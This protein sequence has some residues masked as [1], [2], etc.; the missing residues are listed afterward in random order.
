MF[1]FV[2]YALRG[3]WRFSG[4]DSRQ[5]FW[6]WVGF[7][8]VCDMVLAAAAILPAMFGTMARLQAYAAAH[9]DEVTVESSPGGTSISVH[10]P[11][12]GLMPDI[13]GFMVTNAF[14]TV[15]SVLL[16]AAAVTRRL[17]DTGRR[18]WW[19]LLPLPPL[20]VGLAVFP[21]FFDAM[22]SGGQAPDLRLFGLLSLNNLTYIILLGLLAA[23][24]L[25]P[26]DPL[27]NR[28]GE[29]PA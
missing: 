12:P 16:L 11:V 15:A 14:A 27:P 4:R 26:G 19:G 24:C 13:H 3:L 25:R 23:L 20:G 29:P 7:V 8:L 22:A 2:T 28:F 5:Q 18:G 17:H 1:R 10:G 9:P 6:P 21:R